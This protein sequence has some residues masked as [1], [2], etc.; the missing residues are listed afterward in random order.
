MFGKKKESGIAIMHYEG[1]KQ[2]AA[3]Y[4]VR[5]DVKG[6]VL[7]IKRIKPETIVTLPINRIMSFTAMEESRFMQQYKALFP[8]LQGA[9]HMCFSPDDVFSDTLHH[10]DKKESS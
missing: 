3:D 1:I 6:D 8:C 9:G 7:E 2:F 5:M 4:P 10:H